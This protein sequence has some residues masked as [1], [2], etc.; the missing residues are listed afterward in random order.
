MTEHGVV[1]LWKWSGARWLAYAEAGGRV[2]PGSTD[3]IIVAND[4]VL[5][6]LE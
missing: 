4:T 6:T 5:I 3:F 2:V 1:A